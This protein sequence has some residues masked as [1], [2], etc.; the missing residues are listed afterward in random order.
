MSPRLPLPSFG[1]S[2][3]Q[4]VDRPSPQQIHAAAVAVDSLQDR[5]RAIV[6]EAKDR[7]F[8]TRETMRAYLRAERLCLHVDE[9]LRQFEA[10]RRLR[11][12][13]ALDV[14]Q[15]CAEALGRSA[16]L[17]DLHAVIGGNRG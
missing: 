5:L 14:A 17:A 4:L 11:A 8:A 10:G 12:S 9:A 16:L 3:D 13:A 6:E 2:P 7:R 15:E 1:V